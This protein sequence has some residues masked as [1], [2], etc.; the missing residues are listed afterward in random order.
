MKR[1]PKTWFAVFIALVF[2]G[3][4][5]TGF[6]IR[7]SIESTV[8]ARSRFWAEPDEPRST[9]QLVTILAKELGLTESQHQQIEGALNQRREAIHAFREDIRKRTEEQRR[10]VMADI[11]RVLTPD[12]R[13]RFESFVARRRAERPD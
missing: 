1:N 6:L 4:V 3:G 5:G 11:E 7:P 8:V 9:S 2:V 12:Q 10:A 13:Q